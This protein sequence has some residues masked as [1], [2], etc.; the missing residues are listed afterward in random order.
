MRLRSCI[1]DGVSRGTLAFGRAM[2]TGAITRAVRPASAS[3]VAL[4]LP[5]VAVGP[6]PSSKKF[7]TS[8]TTMY[9][10]VVPGSSELSS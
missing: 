8:T 9:E 1:D 5:D 2:R 6:Y 10:Y 7:G 3:V 4:A